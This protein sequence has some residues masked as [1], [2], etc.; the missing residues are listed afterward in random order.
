M[1]PKTSQRNI[2]DIDIQFSFGHVCD[3][4]YLDVARCKVFA[5]V[6]TVAANESDIAV[7]AVAA[8]VAAD[9]AAAVVPQL[10][11]RRPQ[12]LPVVERYR[13]QRQRQPPPDAAVADVDAN[14]VGAIVR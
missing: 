8:V 6:A 5:I 9:V 14:V 12:L 13:R 1:L 7:A 3:L 10:P 4:T 11:P 2:R